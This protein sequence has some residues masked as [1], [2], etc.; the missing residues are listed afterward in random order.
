M[1]RMI[2]RTPPFE[3]AAL[4]HQKRPMYAAPSARAHTPD[5]T[6]IDKARAAR[7]AGSTS[8]PTTRSTASA[9]G[10]R[11]SRSTASSGIS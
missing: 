2:V 7:V 11:R 9:W 5:S 10:D 3:N 6:S 8:N 4:A 1:P